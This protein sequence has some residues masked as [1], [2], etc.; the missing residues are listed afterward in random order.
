MH[1]QD[2]GSVITTTTNSCNA[3]GVHRHHVCPSD[4]NTW[5]K[6][7]CLQPIRLNS[8][9]THQ[10][11]ELFLRISSVQVLE[12]APCCDTIFIS[13]PGN[14]EEDYFDD[15]FEMEACV[16]ANLS[17]VHVCTVGATGV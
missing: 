3:D 1:I 17:R 10:D 16:C 11:G 4:G 2:K 12:L 6:L 7:Y 5:Q 15:Y 14:G 8:A 9:L 13:Y